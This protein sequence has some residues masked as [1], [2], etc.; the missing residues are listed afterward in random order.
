MILKMCVRCGISVVIIN[1]FV[2]TKFIW[3]RLQIM[4]KIYA[5]VFMEIHAYTVDHLLFFYRPGYSLS[6]A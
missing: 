3:T 2:Q 6:D 5:R 1:A 4:C